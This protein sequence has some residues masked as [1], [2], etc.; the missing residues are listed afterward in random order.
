MENHRE[1]ILVIFNKL[2]FMLE[3]T[4]LSEIFNAGEELEMDLAKLMNYSLN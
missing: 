3:L 2:I 4:K 1:I